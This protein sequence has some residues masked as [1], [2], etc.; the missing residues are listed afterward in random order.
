[1]QVAEQ[2]GEAIVDPKSYADS[3]ELDVIFNDLRARD[4]LAKVHP[5][6]YDPF[7]VVSRHADILNIERR[8]DDFRNGTGSV[9]IFARSWVDMS[10]EAYGEPNFTHS[11]V[12]VDGKEHKD[13][14][15]IAFR[16]FTPKAIKAMED[17][18]RK[19]ARRSID[20]MLVCDG[21][22]D[23]AQLVA[24]AYPLRSVMVALGIPS[25]DESFL[26][27]TAHAMHSAADP[28]YSFSPDDAAAVTQK[29]IEDLEAYYEGVT[30]KFRAEPAECVNSLIANAKI[31][32][33]YLSRRQLMGYY[34]ITAT[35]GHD[36]TAFTIAASMAQLAERP[37]LLARLKSDPSAISA[38]VE[39]S[40]R[41]A[42]PVKNFMRTAERDTEINGTPVSK[43]DWIM[44]AYH[45]ANRDETVF[46][47]PFE[48]DIDRRA[49]VQQLSFGSGPHVC[50]GQHLARLEMRILW[51]EL[52][53]RLESV[54]L[55]GDVKITQSNF[56][57]G[58]KSVPIHFVVNPAQ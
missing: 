15:A 57:C 22:C 54:S 42:T 18:I 17:S 11:L 40:I 2:I 14:R 58:P 8:A 33:E 32:G 25:E 19:V 37:E 34:I 7:W 48:F 13:L 52:L 26:L 56:V 46:E 51:E 44:L 50:L 53:P 21:S 9:I 47:R 31:D 12:E 28:D 30:E 6:G 35:A 36:T 43:G 55:S 3:A 38:F 10:M 16:E 27:K 41:W 5:E 4:A 24:Y 23:F 39:E 49:N 45:S 20:D 29:A 1:M